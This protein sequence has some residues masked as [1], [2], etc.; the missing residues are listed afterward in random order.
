MACM[1][2]EGLLA[3][4]TVMELKDAIWMIVDC[5]QPAI[6][7]LPVEIYRDELYLRTGSR[8]GSHN[9]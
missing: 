2:P 7:G 8:I 1:D 9:T 5:H 6:G 3:R 4:M